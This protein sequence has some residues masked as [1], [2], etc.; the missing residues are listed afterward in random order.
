LQKEKAAHAQTLSEL[1]QA[2]ERSDALDADNASLHAELEHA[3]ASAIAEQE[4]YQEAAAKADNRRRES[5]AV[6]CSE[7]ASV[8][9]RCSNL[10]DENLALQDEV[11]RRTA[12]LDALHA[13]QRSALMRVGA[14]RR[15]EK[16]AV[17]IQR[18]WRRWQRHEAAAA[19]ARDAQGWRAERDV[20]TQQQRRAAAQTGR[21]LVVATMQQVEATVQT[22][23]MEMLV[24]GPVKRKLKA[25]RGGLGVQGGTTAALSNSGAVRASRRHNDVAV[26]A[27]RVKSLGTYVPG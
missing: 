27:G 9:A 3:K 1:G 22:L 2:N 25:A 6:L 26:P 14:S 23:L 15:Q 13:R 12:E 20:L 19:A 4:A 18:H 5:E 11:T 24:S 17:V 10:E 16:A 7:L 8:R 21:T